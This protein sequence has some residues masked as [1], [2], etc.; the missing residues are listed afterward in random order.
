MRVLTISIL[1]F[2][3]VGLAACGG[4]ETE[5]VG[6]TWQWEAF[7]DTAGLNDL[8]VP[9]PENYTLT[10]NEDGT[11][12]IKAD[13]NQVVWSYQLNESQLTFDTTGPS[14]LAMCPEGSLDQQFLERLGNTVSYVLQDGKL[15]LNLLA[16]AGNLVFH[17]K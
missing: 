12:S 8:S 10:L 3:T 5:V 17:S 9:N 2:L 13:C 6:P 16:D 4:G 1:I 15:H 11:A 14:T 7:E